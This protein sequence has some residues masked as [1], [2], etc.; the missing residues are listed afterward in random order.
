MSAIEYFR[1]LLTQFDGIQASD[2][3][4][5]DIAGMRPTQYALRTEPAQ[6]VLRRYKG[7]AAVR[8][9]AVALEGVCPTLSDAER[10]QNNARYEE[11]ARWLDMQTK[12]RKLPK[13]DGMRVLKVEALRLICAT[14]RG[15]DTGAISCIE[16]TYYGDSF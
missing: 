15:R 11:L 8:M 12:S 13:M 7:S 2:D 5:I 3:I 6:Q 16:L 9:Y 1:D 10:M 4:T 14:G